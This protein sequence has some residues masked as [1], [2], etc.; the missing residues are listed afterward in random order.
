MVGHGAAP[1]HTAPMQT[2]SKADWHR[3]A[4]S[5]PHPTFS[6]CLLLPRTGRVGPSAD[7]PVS[8]FAMA[9]LHEVWG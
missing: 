1:K 5:L 7:G 3:I 2:K 6:L 9:M 4:D 8:R